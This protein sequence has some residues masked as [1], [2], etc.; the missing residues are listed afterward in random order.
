MSQPTPDDIQ[1][2]K[3]EVWAYHEGNR[4][5]LPWRRTHDPYPILVSEIMLQQTQVPRVV[6]KY[7]AFLECFPTV[8]ALAQAPA[9]DVL[10]VWQGLG[11]NRR[12]LALQRAAGMI[13]AE[14]AGVIPRSLEELRRLPGVG[15][16]PAAALCVYSYGA[17][18]PF[19]ETNVR[20]AFIHFFFQECPR[21]SD[22]DLL[23]LVEFALDRDK[24]REW[25]YALM[26]YGTWIKKTHRNPGRKSSHHTLQTPF[27]GSRREVR[28]AALRALLAAGPAGLALDALRRADP[29]I[30]ARD[31]SELREILAGL[32]AEGFL[33]G[34]G[35][36][37]R[38]R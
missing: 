28:A 11:Y 24:P 36:R 19:I 30:A 18:L 23:P 15:P 3:D 32:T 33:S 7:A 29:V 2:F 1:R 10:T 12:A 20:A 26:D 5:D 8:A 27:A 34:D 31:P 21:V 25:Y 9:A 17:A 4:R 14:H 35:E 6:T 38:V 16:A 22:A 37:Y 13:Q